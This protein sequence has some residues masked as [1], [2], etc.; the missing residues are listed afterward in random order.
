MQALGCPIWG[1][2]R[3]GPYNTTKEKNNETKRRKRGDEVHSYHVMLSVADGYNDLLESAT[4]EQY[5]HCRLCLFALELTFPHPITKQE[6][7]VC[8]SELQWYQ[9]LRQ[10]CLRVTQT[11]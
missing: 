1:D 2:K 3:H 6:T 10:Y 9:D 4:V 7:T 11:K 5:P 8:I